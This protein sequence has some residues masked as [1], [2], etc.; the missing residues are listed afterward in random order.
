MNTERVYEAETVSTERPFPKAF[1]DR[2]FSK[3]FTQKPEPEPELFST[4]DLEMKPK[5]DN[6]DEI[7]KLETEAKKL[8]QLS[9]QRDRERVTR[10]LSLPSI[11]ESPGRAND[12]GS[13]AKQW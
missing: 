11:F 6:R 8:L 7:S 9:E 12:P 2:P 5:E 1:T 3:A 4:N 13:T 10:T